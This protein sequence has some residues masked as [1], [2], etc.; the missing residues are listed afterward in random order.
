MWR[1]FHQER[2]LFACSCNLI[3]RLPEIN[4]RKDAMKSTIAALVL[5]FAISATGGAQA[6]LS[7]PKVGV[8]P[9]RVV[10]NK[11]DASYL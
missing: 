2:D 4:M 9:V 8:N 1:G 6:R 3:D 5:L 11:A 7:L 10:I